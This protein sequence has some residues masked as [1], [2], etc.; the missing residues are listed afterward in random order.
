VQDGRI[1]Q[2]SQICHVF[3]FL[4]FRRIDR[5]AL[6]FLDHLFVLFSLARYVPTPK[7]IKTAANGQI[8][9]PKFQNHYY[10]STPLKF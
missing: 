6:V 5:K 9:I 1:V 10:S 7:E 3:H 2:V 4:E 8:L